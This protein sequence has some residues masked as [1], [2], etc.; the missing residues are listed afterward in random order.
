MKKE[1]EI[2]RLTSYWLR[3]KPTDGNLAI[4]ELGWVEIGELLDALTRRGHVVS[5]D[6]LF[7][8]STSF[9]KIR[10]EFD[11]SKKKIRATHGHSIPVTIEKTATPP[12]V[13]YHGTALKSLKAIID[14]GLKAMNR[15]FVHLSSQYDAA[16]VVGQRHGKAL[17][18]EVDAEGLHQDGCTFYQTSDNV[19]L[20][21]EVPAKYLQFGPW[22]STSPDEPELV[23]ELKREVGQGH[24][25]FG[26]TENLKAIMRRVDRD[27]CLFIDKQ[28]QEIYEVHLTWSKGIESDARLPSITYHKNLDDWLATGFLEDYRDF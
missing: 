17:V 2:S 10:W 21:N 15:Q 23:N 11:G 9:D 19:W 22:Y 8:L 18:L 25:L 14:G 12:S 28:S 4:D 3:H 7:I 6:E 5:T 24:L 26:K 13:L 20:I 27:D 16:L 1:S